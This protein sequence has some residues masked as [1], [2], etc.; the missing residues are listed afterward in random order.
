MIIGMIKAHP[1]KNRD[2]KASDL[3]VGAEVAAAA[4]HLVHCLLLCGR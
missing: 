1:D 2:G 4:W 3:G